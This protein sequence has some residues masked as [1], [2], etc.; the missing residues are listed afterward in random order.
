MNYLAHTLLSKRDIRYQTG[1]LL[2]DPM[3]GKV[4]EGAS[5]LYKDGMKMHTLIDRFTDGHPKFLES[6]KRLGQHGYLRGVVV[7]IIYDHYL[8]VN[9]NQYV[10][11]PL[12]NYLKLFY[13]NYQNL[14]DKIPRQA[15]VFLNNLQKHQVLYS[16]DKLSNLHETFYRLDKRLSARLLS[17][18][19]TSA[20]M[21]KLEDKYSELAND[22]LDFFPDLINY[23]LRETDFKEEEHFFL[24]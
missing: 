10:E 15:E 4:W 19:S 8:T 9:W 16:Y 14:N 24:K 3:K 20:Y 2:A 6:K 17:K 1:N 23:F 12:N 5:Y 18:E 11:M 7:D 13:N 21:V 22:F